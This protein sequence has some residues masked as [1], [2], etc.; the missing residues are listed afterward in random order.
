MC[1]NGGVKEILNRNPGTER[2]NQDSALS[3]FF[4]CF[5]K[6]IAKLTQIVASHQRKISSQ[7]GQS[8]KVFPFRKLLK[9]IYFKNDQIFMICL[10]VEVLLR[11]WHLKRLYTQCLLSYNILCLICST[12]LLFEILL[13]TRK[14]VWL[15]CICYTR[16]SMISQTHLCVLDHLPNDNLMEG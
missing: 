2:G 10:H 16:K 9:L 13:W 8:Q 6:C 14:K 1:R 15:T 7:L 11:C 5:L 3:F 12:S 4:S